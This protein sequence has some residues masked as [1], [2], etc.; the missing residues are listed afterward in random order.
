MSET[1]RNSGRADKIIAFL[2]RLPIPD[3]PAVGQLITIDPWEERFIRDIYEPEHADGRRVVRRAVLSVARKNR[4]SLIIAGLLL[5]HLIGPE[6][7]RNAQIY[8]CAVTQ[9]QAKVIFKMCVQMI[10]MKSVLR[11]YL[12]VTESTSTIYVKRTDCKARGSTY[13]ALSADGP[14]KHGLGADFFVYDEFGEARDGDLYNVLLDSQQLRLSPLAVVISTQNND[15]T[16]PL[17]QLIDDG[18]S[19]VDPTLVCHLYAADDDCALDDRAQWLKANPTLATWK[20]Y[21]AIEIAAGEAKRMPAQE[22]NFRRRYLNQRVSLHSNLI[23]QSDWRACEDKTISYEPKQSIFLALDL[24]QRVDLTAL[25][26]ITTGDVS[27]AQAWFWKPKQYVQEHTRRDRVR[28]D[29]F[30]DQGLLELSDGKAVSPRAVALKI[31]ELCETYDVRGL[32]YDRWK[33]DELLTYFDDI[34]FEAQQGEG[35]GLALYDWGQGYKDM[36]PAIDAFEMEILQGTLKHPGHPLLTWNVLN[37]QAISDPAGNRKLDKSK[38]TLRIDG[39]QA[40]AMAVGLKAR[41]RTEPVIVSPWEDP[42]FKLGAI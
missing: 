12:G 16:H 34:G 11:D 15:P 31:A 21:E 23:A 40:L 6:S 27:Q 38:A 18:L 10:E 5:V 3:G 1:V 35:Y 36:G 7:Q 26:A 20:P 13:Q 8:T 22:Q 41:T 9:K 42:D 39:A 32:A 28:Y 19:G 2:E 30:A 29:L 33:M 17:S 14:A 4:K 37:A 24:S 25:V